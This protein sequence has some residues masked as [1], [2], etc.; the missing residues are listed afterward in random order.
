MKRSPA[1]KRWKWSPT[2]MPHVKKNLPRQRSRDSPRRKQ[3]RRT[4][5]TASSPRPRPSTTA[6]RAAT[7]ALGAGARRSAA[8]TAT[9]SEYAA[10]SGSGTRCS[11][12]RCPFLRVLRLEEVDQASQSGK[13]HCMEQQRP[14]AGWI[15]GQ[16]AFAAEATIKARILFEHTTPKSMRLTCISPITFPVSPGSVALS[17]RVFIKPS[18]QSEGSIIA[19]CI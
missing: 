19:F 4:S 2:T 18:C 9:R 11:A 3:R 8:E 1:L 12:G 14:F 6:T 15:G 10:L 17:H 16:H 7:R 5:W 13:S